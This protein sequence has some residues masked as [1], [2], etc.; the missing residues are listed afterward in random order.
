[1]LLALLMVMVFSCTKQDTPD[2][3]VLKKLYKSY[4]NGEIVEGRIEDTKAYACQID[5]YDAALYL[6]N[7][8]GERI[9]ICSYAWN[10]VDSLC[11]DFEQVEVIYRKAGM[12]GL[13]GVDKYRLSK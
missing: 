12:H 13:E 1:M 9:A 5:A 2:L 10:Y 11:Y 4:Q 7:T 3:K 6:F 8:K